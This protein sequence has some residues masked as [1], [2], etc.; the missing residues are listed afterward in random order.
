MRQ[1]ILRSATQ[2]FRGKPKLS[3]FLL[4]YYGPSLEVSTPVLMTA[5]G[6]DSSLQSKQLTIHATFTTWQFAFLATQ[7]AF[8]AST[9][10]ANPVVFIHF[11]AFAACH[12]LNALRAEE[13]IADLTA[14]Q[15]STPI[16]DEAPFAIYTKAPIAFAATEQVRMLVETISASSNPAVLTT[17]TWF[18][19]KTERKRTNVTA[20]ETSP[21]NAVIAKPFVAI[22]AIAAIMTARTN[23]TL[24]ACLKLIL[25]C[26]IQALSAFF[27]P[28]VASATPAVGILG[29][30]N[31]HR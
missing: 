24:V 5:V 12:V 16:A 2:A 28:R 4:D 1:K 30:R 11:A 9:T 8:L 31:W 3:R 23:I 10:T 29:Q 17:Q 7:E 26:V 14:I 19:L 13:A 20:K 25:Q 21:T 6:A 27:S 18:A 15:G 22:E